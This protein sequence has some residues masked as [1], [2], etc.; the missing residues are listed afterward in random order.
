[1][2][3]KGSIVDDFIHLNPQR[4]ISLA[5]IFRTIGQYISQGVYMQTLQNIRSSIAPLKS[6]IYNCQ[7]GCVLSLAQ[8]YMKM[9]EKTEC[10]STNKID[11]TGC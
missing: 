4:S 9:H 6:G 10:K 7:I 2:P 11:F 3:I 1:M 8:S 5:V